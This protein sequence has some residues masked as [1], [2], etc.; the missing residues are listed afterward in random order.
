MTNTYKHICDRIKKGRKLFAVLIDPEKFNPD[1]V[2]E[3][4]RCAVDFFFVGGSTVL[5]TDFSKT[6]SY[7]RK[8]S[9]TPTVIFPGDEE[10]V[11]GNADALL[12][13]SLL[14]GRNAEYLVG[15]HIKAAFELRKSKLEIIPTGYILTDGGKSAS[16]TAT[17]SGTNGIPFSD[18]KQIRA[19]AIAGE[20]MGCKL[21]YLEG[22]SGT[23]SEVPASIIKTVK[24]D[25][26]VPLIVGGGI[27][28]G[29]KA[30]KAW[31][32]GADL[33]VA[34]NGIEKNISLI[35]EIS[36]QLSVKKRV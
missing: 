9:S 22:G 14:S 15:K 27:D 2:H 19:T 20:L 3:A 7:I 36:N 18:S 34:G 26:T 13:L 35:R 16:A 28:S 17:V 11:S 8:H 33:V 1:V 31:D 23:A 5:R 32:A 6:L 12:L 30:K 10:Q 25:L 21:I 4:D 29:A 24:K